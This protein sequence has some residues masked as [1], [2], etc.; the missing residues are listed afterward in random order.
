MHRSIHVPSF[1]FCFSGFPY[2]CNHGIT[3]IPK[4]ESIVAYRLH[5]DGGR[6]VSFLVFF[7]TVWI[8]S[9]ESGRIH[10]H[11][12]PVRRTHSL[13][14][15]LYLTDGI[16]MYCTYIRKSGIEL[17]LFCVINVVRYARYTQTHAGGERR[18]VNDA[19]EERKWKKDRKLLDN[20]YCHGKWPIC[21][22]RSLSFSH[23]KFI[24]GR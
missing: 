10:M 16:Y 23:W 13:E 20:A 8:G 24:L 21:F 1:S 14:Y 2:V 3:L 5:T 6:H 22:S 19:R 17:N 15:P 7:T 18:Q 9:K 4:F 12:Y 11:I